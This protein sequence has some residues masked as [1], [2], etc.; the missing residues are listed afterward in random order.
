MIWKYSLN[1]K[2][3][4]LLGLE[5]FCEID[6]VSYYKSKFPAIWQCL[7]FHFL[8]CLMQT[9]FHLK[10]KNIFEWKRYICSVFC[11]AVLQRIFIIGMV[12]QQFPMHLWHCTL[13]QYLCDCW[14]RQ[15]IKQ[16]H[17]LKPLRCDKDNSVFDF[18]IDV[19][20]A[21]ISFLL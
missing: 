8:R 21:S 11:Q 20:K 17:F 4:N 13:C 1:W 14:V 3:Y 6:S 10:W 12:L 9:A 7:S 5:V 18:I 19:Y 15:S 16:L 2:C